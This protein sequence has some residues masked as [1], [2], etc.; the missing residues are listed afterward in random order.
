MTPPLTDEKWI[1]YILILSCLVMLAPNRKHLFGVYTLPLIVG[2]LYPTTKIAQ[3]FL[4][5][6]TWYRSY[7]ADIGYIAFSSWVIFNFSLL[8]QKKFNRR[9]EVV[10]KLKEFRAWTFT[11]GFAAIFMEILQLQAQDSIGPNLSI[12]KNRTGRGDPIDLYIFCGM[13]V[14]QVLFIDY[15]KKQYIELTEDKPKKHS[16]KSR[17]RP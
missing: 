5:G 7:F 1:G 17:S 6:P 8:L 14:L 3:Y 11:A 2:I 4:I 16:G 12:V 10:A 13:C 9:Y 15:K